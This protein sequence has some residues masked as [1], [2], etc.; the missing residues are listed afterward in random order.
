MT[1]PRVFTQAGPPVITQRTG[2]PLAEARD[3]AWL[4]SITPTSSLISRGQG[5]P[6]GV[7]RFSDI[8]CLFGALGH[9]QS[10]VSGSAVECTGSASGQTDYRL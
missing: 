3:W 10:L 7:A 9:A 1:T 6:G 4:C 2:I 8:A 5:S